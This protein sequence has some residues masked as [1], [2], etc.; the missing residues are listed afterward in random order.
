VRSPIAASDVC[1]G[2]VAHIPPSNPGLEPQRHA[3]RPVQI[4]EVEKAP[5]LDLHGAVPPLPS[6]RGDVGNY[7]MGWAEV[8]TVPSVELLLRTRELPQV[9]RH[10]LHFSR[11]N[12]WQGAQTHLRTSVSCA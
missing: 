3:A 12:S 2:D 11:V 5:A 7:A 6:N 1:C 10:N 8:A 4:L 9:S